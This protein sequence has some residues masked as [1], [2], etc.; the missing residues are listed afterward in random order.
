[1]ISYLAVFVYMAMLVHLYNEVYIRTK[2]EILGESF[3]ALFLVQV[4]IM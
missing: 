4:L 1:M 3:V 2:R